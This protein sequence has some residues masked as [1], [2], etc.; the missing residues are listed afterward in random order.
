[1]QVDL[2]QVIHQSVINILSKTTQYT[3]WLTLALGVSTLLNSCR[4]EVPDDMF[5]IIP[6]TSDTT[7]IDTI[8]RGGKDSTDMQPIDTTA[9]NNCD[10]TIIYFNTQIL[11][12]LVGNCAMAGCHDAISAQD[13][14]VLDSYEG[15]MNEKLIKGTDPDDSE[16]F[17]KISEKD[18]KDRMPPPPRQ[19]LNEDQIDLIKNWILQG[20]KNTECLSEVRCDTSQASYVSDVAPILKNY[21]TGCHGSTNPEAGLNLNLYASVSA[22]AKTGKLTGVLNWNAGFI[23]MPLGG[24]KLPDCELNLINAWIRQGS[25]DN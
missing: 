22:V 1:M 24:S 4:T 2:S 11:P 20:A 3:I 14:F 5:P 13:G 15:V 10:T 9:R 23:K 6:E 21:C 17:E 8:G 16:L 7:M 19:G 18:V 12:I 25:L